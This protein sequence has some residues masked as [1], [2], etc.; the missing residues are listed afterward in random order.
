MRFLS[1]LVV[2]GRCPE[3]TSDFCP[4]LRRV[5][6]FMPSRWPTRAIE[7]R[8]F[9]VSARSSKTIATARS[10]SS[11]GCAFLDAMSPNFPRGHSLQGSRGGPHS[12]YAGGQDRPCERRLLYFYE[13]VLRTTGGS[14]D[15]G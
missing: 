6:V 1:S 13:A 4:Q 10:R 12:L 7:P 3:S 5:S 8:A 14:H 11:A 15:S 9:P 2:P